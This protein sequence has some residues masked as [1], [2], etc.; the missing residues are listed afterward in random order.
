MTALPGVVVA[1]FVIVVGS[2]NSGCLLPVYIPAADSI[3]EIENLPSSAGKPVAMGLEWSEFVLDE[4]KGRILAWGGFPDAHRSYIHWNIVGVHAHSMPDFKRRIDIS[5]P[6]RKIEMQNH[7][8]IDCRI[9]LTIRDGATIESKIVGGGPCI[10]RI[11]LP[12]HYDENECRVDLNR[13]TLQTRDDPGQ[14]VV[15][16]GTIRAERGEIHE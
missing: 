10:C 14:R 2:M 16:S 8:P 13:I 9:E 4:R 15:V 7:S 11:A 1:V 3:V 6:R 12:V 5:F